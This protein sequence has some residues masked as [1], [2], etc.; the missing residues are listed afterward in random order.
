M[1]NVIYELNRRVYFYNY[2]SSQFSLLYDFNL[3]AGESFMLYPQGALEDSF[4]VVVDS[5]GL[6]TINGF[7]RKT[8]FIH[9]QPFPPHIAYQFS[10]KVIEGIGSIGC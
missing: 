8:Q 10:G 4:L 7:L 2:Q 5:T 9:A 6:D 3:N 1:T